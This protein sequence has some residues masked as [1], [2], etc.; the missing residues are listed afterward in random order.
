MTTTAGGASVAGGRTAWARNLAAPVRGFLHAENDGAL[1]IAV[2]IAAALVWA[3]LAPD[4][5]ASLW[6]TRLS[7]ALGPHELGMSLREWVNEGL[8]ALFF[9]VVGLEAKRELDVG[10]L[11]ERARL[12]IPVVAAVGGMAAAAGI[13][14]AINAGGHGARGWGAAV[15]TDTALALGAL[16]AVTRGVAVR[17]RVFLLTLVV[18]D[19]LAALLLITL[20]YTDAVSVMALGVAAALFGALVALRYAGGTWRGPA[21]VFLGVGLW[22]A[23]H[24]SGVDPVVTGLAVGLVISAYLPSRDDLERSTALARSFREQPSPELAYSARASVTSAIS[25][26]ERLQYRLHPWTSRAIVPLFALANAGV[27]L[28]REL[29]A[30]AVRSPVTLGVVA[31]YVV[32]KPVGILLSS[33]MA[34]LSGRGRA[35]RTT[36]WPGLV[37]AGTSAGI[38]FTVSLLVAA[39][40]FEGEL[41]EEA[42][43]GILATAAI[44]PLLAWV[45]WQVTVRLPDETR[46]RNRRGLA[47]A[48]L[49]L[50]E[51]VDPER[52]HVRGA[53]DAPVTIV[54]YGDFECPYCAAA[55]PAVAEVLEQFPGEVRHV[56]RHLPLSDVHP[57]AAMAA[58]AAEAAAGQGA[59]WEMHDRLLAD[60]GRLSGMDLV[61]H[62]S[63]LGLDTARFADDLHHH[64]FAER[65]TDDVRSADES[66]VSGTPTFFINGRRHAGAYDTEALAGAVRAAPRAGVPA[67]A[68]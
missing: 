1:G 21:V 38:G 26:N 64:R 32:G 6:G 9:L 29:V 34:T 23:L 17:L 41:L 59:F 31:A 25:L 46:A 27:H 18:I 61:R 65:V 60:Q 44:S 55:A 42:K 45:A 35:A 3:N 12:A 56:W 53:P 43:I 28:D 37:V 52:D 4:G 24:E 11:R 68:A 54:E 19:D 7:V 20:G 15:S 62:A 63:E 33:W 36:T 67:Q 50:A 66:G 22:V 5:Y 2:A 49:D 51:E 57:R 16:T 40:A 47:P 8:M 14:L 58:E 39:L 30:R 10:E 48:L 13:Y